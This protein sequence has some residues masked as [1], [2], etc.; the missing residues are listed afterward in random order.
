MVPLHTGFEPRG[1]S[2]KIE[3]EESTSETFSRTKRKP[4]LVAGASNLGV[5][6]FPAFFDTKGKSN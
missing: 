1:A 5:S 2:E 3:F 4:L 6:I